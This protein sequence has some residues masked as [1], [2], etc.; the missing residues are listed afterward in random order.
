MNPWRGLMLPGAQTPQGT[1]QQPDGTTRH[2]RCAHFRLRPIGMITA[3]QAVI[4]IQSIAKVREIESGTRIA[5]G[6]QL[7]TAGTGQGFQGQRQIGPGGEQLE[8]AGGCGTQPH[9]ATLGPVNAMGMPVTTAS[10]RYS[11]FILCHLSY[12]LVPGLA[13]CLLRSNTG[14]AIVLTGPG[15]QSPAQQISPQLFQI[16]RDE[17]QMGE[18]G[19][20]LEAVAAERRRQPAGEHFAL[21]PGRVAR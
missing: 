10:R 19:G 13:A 11:S 3:R 2:Q 20:R 6:F 15:E 7:D 5:M 21:L 18:S 12:L 16:Q 17:R 4:F 14:V 1:I 9:H 8:P